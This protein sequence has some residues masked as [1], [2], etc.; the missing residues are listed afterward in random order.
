MAVGVR[1]VSALCTDHLSPVLLSLVSGWSLFLA[2]SPLCC[3]WH[4][5][6]HL[7]TPKQGNDWDF[8]IEMLCEFYNTIV[9][10]TGQALKALN[11]YKKHRDAG[12]DVPWTELK[13]MADVCLG[14]FCGC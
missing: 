14:G 4:V 7:S 12:T 9:A 13:E 1:L 8:L 6:S 5:V 2:L 3:V 10:K 11:S